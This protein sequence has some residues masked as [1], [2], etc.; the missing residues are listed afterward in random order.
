MQHSA[1]DRPTAGTIASEVWV[2]SEPIVHIFRGLILAGTCA[3][4]V[5]AAGATGAAEKVANGAADATP[6]AK[7]AMNA[8]DA[9][10]S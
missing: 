6:G 4:Y 9:T 3:L 8:T 1:H 5:A 7:V 2:P 10:D